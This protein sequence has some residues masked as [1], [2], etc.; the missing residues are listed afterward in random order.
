M[1]EIEQHPTDKFRLLLIGASGQF[2]SKL[3]RLLAAEDAIELVLAGRRRAPLYALQQS[4]EASGILVLDRNAI[5][6]TTLLDAGINMVADLSGPY[7]E[8]QTGVV[9]AAI[10]AGVHYIDIADSRKFINAIAQFDADATSAACA[11]ITGASSTPALSH[12]V[13]DDLTEAP[14]I[15]LLLKLLTMI[16][17]YHV[18]N[19][20]YQ[21]VSEPV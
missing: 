9:H 12:A 20:H 13:I 3:A 7:Q 14:A 17:L 8:M 5:T 6:A 10:E 19:Q 1:S 21:R 16:F 2:G 18:I 4:L 11:I 15:P